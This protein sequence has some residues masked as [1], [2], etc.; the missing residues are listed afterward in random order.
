[1]LGSDKVIYVKNE[2]NCKKDKESVF[3]W[4]VPCFGSFI[5]WMLLLDAFFSHMFWLC[6]VSVPCMWLTPPSPYHCPLKP[7][8]PVG[9]RQNWMK[10]VARGL[11]GP[12]LGPATAKRVSLKTS[13]SIKYQTHSRT[14]SIPTAGANNVPAEEASAF[15]FPAVETRL[16]LR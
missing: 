13:L 9:S 10:D 2:R 14:H 4:Q 16:W 7:S 15:Y 3:F 12:G 6:R 1:M 5:R 11:L 8:F